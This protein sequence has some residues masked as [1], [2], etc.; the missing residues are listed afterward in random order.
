MN[1]NPITVVAQIQSKRGEETQVQRELLSLIAPTRK[2]AGC[3]NYDLHRSAD[4]PALFLFHE[5]WA[6]RADL[7]RHLNSPHL[8]AVLAKVGGRLAGPASIS[9]WEKL[10]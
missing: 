9:I 2:E 4:N 5:N 8:Q 6:S 10:A 3:L 7:E 1:A